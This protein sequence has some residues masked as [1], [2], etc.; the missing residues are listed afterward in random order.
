MSLREPH[1]KMSKSDPNPKSMILITES[2]E[3]IHQKIKAAVTDSMTDHISY[4]PENRP[5]VS[6]LLEIMSHF[7]ERRRTPEELAR[8]HE[9]SALS[10]LKERV[11]E[12]V[13]HGLTGVQA[14][15]ERIMAADEGRY[16]DHVA[17]RGAEKARQSAQ[18]TMALVRQSIGL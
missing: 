15:F 3:A 9:H 5:G 16:L 12:S 10:S 14:E 13:V 1:K 7:D 11:A 18:E 17:S 8:E 6:N 4:D 2:A